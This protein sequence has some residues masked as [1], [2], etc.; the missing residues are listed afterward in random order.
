MILI[1]RVSKLSADSLL[2]ALTIRAENFPGFIEFIAQNLEHL[3]EIVH[4]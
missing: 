3:P 4:K 2:T 1:Q